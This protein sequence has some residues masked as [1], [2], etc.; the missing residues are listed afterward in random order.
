MFHK[1]DKDASI[2]TYYIIWPC[3]I[4]VSEY[5]NPHNYRVWGSQ[6]LNEVIDSKRLSLDKRVVWLVVFIFSQRTVTECKKAT[7]FPQI[8]TKWCAPY[9]NLGVR[10]VLKPKFPNCWIGKVSPMLS[11]I[12][13]LTP[14]DLFFDS[15]KTLFLKWNQSEILKHC[16]A[17]VAIVLLD[18]FPATCG[19]NL[20]IEWMYVG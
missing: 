10:E 2:K 11:P 4:Q 1:I 20:T 13:D 5:L 8:S 19:F 15:V 9:V 6:T 7:Y 3:I 16:T 18:M 17:D 12:L 14:L